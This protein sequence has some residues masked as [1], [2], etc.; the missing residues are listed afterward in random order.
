MVDVAEHDGEVGVQQCA[1]DLCHPPVGVVE[2][3]VARDRAVFDGEI[4]VIVVEDQGVERQVAVWVERFLDD[5]LSRDVV[6]VVA[7]EF[8]DV[9]GG[10]VCGF[11]GR[12]LV[13]GSIVP[14]PDGCADEEIAIN[15]VAVSF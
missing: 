13:R 4:A 10:I 15:F 9:L 14:G 5:D 12:N 11:V 7:N 2:G 6:W 1:F 3:A 8:I